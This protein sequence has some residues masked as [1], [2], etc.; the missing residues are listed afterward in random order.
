MTHKNISSAPWFADAA[1][2]RLFSALNVDGGEVRLVGGCVRDTLLGRV[3]QDVDMATT[4]TPD[5]VQTLLQA[6]QIKTVPTGIAHGTV[7]AIIAH[8]PIEITSLRADLTTDGRHAEVAFGRDW[9]VDAGRR[10]FTINALYADCDGVV[11]DPLDMGFAD[12][13]NKQVRFIGA[14]AQRIAEDYLRILRFFRF[15]FS[16]IPH[17]PMNTPALQ[18]CTQAAAGMDILSGERIQAEMMKLIALSAWHDALLL[19]HRHAILAYCVP[20]FDL[21]L[22][23]RLGD[24]DAVLRLGALMPDVDA[25][26]RLRNAWKLSNAVFTRL[27]GMHEPVRVKAGFPACPQINARMSVADIRRALYYMGKQAVCDRLMLYA[28]KTGE[29]MQSLFE[30]A[31][32][33]EKPRFPLNGDMLHAAGIEQGAD[34]GRVAAHMESWWIAQDFP[35]NE[36]AFMEELRRIA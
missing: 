19:M 2:Q 11:Y 9:S 33:I 10:D 25:V 23:A 24:A 28:A 1:V 13:E 27:L 4:H 20:V 29:N 21:T 18:A 36:P 17:Q 15:H 14:A 7:T 31:K 34:M 32:R 16:L 26:H 22:C 35:Q 3:V 6:A 30:K 8:R 5:S 12:I